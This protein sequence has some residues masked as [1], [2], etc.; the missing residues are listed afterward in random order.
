MTTK[1]TTSKRTKAVVHLPKNGVLIPQKKGAI[2]SHWKLDKDKNTD[3]LILT[4]IPLSLMT[5][6]VMTRIFTSRLLHG[7]LTVS[8]S[9]IPCVP[10]GLFHLLRSGFFPSSKTSFHPPRKNFVKIP[11][12]CALIAPLIR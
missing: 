8:L 1:K 10:S 6:G 7:R 9:S 2:A 12:L 11:I 3:T 4:L 5:N